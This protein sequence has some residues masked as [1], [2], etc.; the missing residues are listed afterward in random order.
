MRVLFADDQIPDEEIP[1]E[2][3]FQ[4]MRAV[5]PQAQEGFIRA[6]QVMRRA[7]RA[8]S[9]DNH[10]VVAHRFQDAMS[11]VQTQEFDVAI[12]D[13]GWYADKSIRE[14]ERAAAYERRPDQPP[15][16]Q[17]IY[18]AR[19]DSQPQL[20]ERAASRGK[21]PFLKP[22]H[23]RFTIPLESR[24]AVIESAD[25]VEAACQSLRATLSFIEHV[26]GSEA[27]PALALQ[28]DL[29][30]LRKAASDGLSRAV[31]REKR[32]DQLTRV[33][34][35]ISIVIVLAGVV[36]LFFFGVPEGAVT[37]AVGVV[38]G[39][40]PRLMF[41]ELHKAREE[42]QGATDNV[43]ALLIAAQRRQAD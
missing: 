25:K 10:V 11:L 32:W 18:S 27:T 41:G 39:L 38:V 26:R 23:E 3:I 42:I 2:D 40:I 9:E 16:A 30:V 6:F 13:L 5:Y 35:T 34:L 12:V 33:L 19:F 36:S 21:L 37:A 31:E 1:D 22:Y 4:A 7:H 17:I 8:V 20:G 15:T 24:E 28:R 29:N 43:N 14:S